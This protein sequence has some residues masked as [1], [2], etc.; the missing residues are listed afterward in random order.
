MSLDLQSKGTIDKEQLPQM[1]TAPI[2]KYP[3]QLFL[4]SL[5]NGTAR[6]WSLYPPSGACA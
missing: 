1:I 3:T 4:T 6:T 2:M 5:P